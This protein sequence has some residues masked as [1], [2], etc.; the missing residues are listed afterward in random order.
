MQL[1]EELLVQIRGYTAVGFE[2]LTVADDGQVMPPKSPS[3][4]SIT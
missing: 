2:F 4:K 1:V 3:F